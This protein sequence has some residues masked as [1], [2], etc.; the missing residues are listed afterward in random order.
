MYLSGTVCGG[1]RGLSPFPSAWLVFAVLTCPSLGEHSEF[2]CD[3]PCLSAVWPPGLHVLFLQHP[4]PVCVMSS[5]QAWSTGWTDR[6]VKH[7]EPPGGGRHR[8]CTRA[9]GLPCGRVCTI[10]THRPSQGARASLVPPLD[11]ACVP[12]GQHTMPLLQALEPGPQGRGAGVPC[13]QPG[14]IRACCLPSLL[15]GGEDS[16]LLPS[17]SLRSPRVLPAAG[18]GRCGGRAGVWHFLL[19]TNACFLQAIC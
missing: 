18:L 2:S 10:R 6:P 5:C 17:E 14:V 9:G 11:G 4:A 1:H 16:S 7:G 15:L 19:S 3:R 13:C 8:L 12:C